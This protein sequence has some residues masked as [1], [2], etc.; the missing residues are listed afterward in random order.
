MKKNIFLNTK[1][2]IFLLLIPIIKLFSQTSISPDTLIVKSACVI[3][4]Q[5]KQI[6]IDSLIAQVPFKVDSV[7]TSFENLKRHVIPF[8]KKSGLKYI[9]TDAVVFQLQHKEHKTVY[10]RKLYEEVAGVI[11]FSP[12]KDACIM[13][14]VTSDVMVL[15]QIRKYYSDL[16]RLR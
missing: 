13:P 16:L 15:N 9:I 12:E 8:L 6:E 11:L 3:M 7:I 10:S 2:S 1:I 5:S 14:M 4:Y